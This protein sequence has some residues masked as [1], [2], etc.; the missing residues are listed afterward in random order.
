[1]SKPNRVGPQMQRA[2][3]I[4]AAN[5]GCHKILVARQITPCPVAE[6][7]WAYGYNPIN[8]AIKAGLIRAE[9]GSDGRYALYA[10]EA[11]R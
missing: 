10:E 8:R 9:Q 11:T 5:P 6:G 3:E 7:N 4:V 1:M 2:V